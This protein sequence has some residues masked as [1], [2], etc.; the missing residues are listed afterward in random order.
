VSY[1][2][3]YAL[4]FHWIKTKYFYQTLCEH[5]EEQNVEEYWKAVE[6]YQSTSHL[7]Q[8]YT[9]ILKRIKKQHDDVDLC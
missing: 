4:F 8:W 1:S 5:L 2:F 3:L 6:E 9:T 7:E